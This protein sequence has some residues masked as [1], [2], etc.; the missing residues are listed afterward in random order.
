MSQGSS[1]RFTEAREYWRVAQ[2]GAMTER[3]VEQAQKV[4]EGAEE[5]VTQR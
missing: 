3:H 4:L 2:H 1:S 5:V